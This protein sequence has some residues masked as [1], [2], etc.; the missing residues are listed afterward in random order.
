MS[1]SLKIRK[2]PP[3]PLN[4]QINEGPSWPPAAF[5]LP[6]AESIADHLLRTFEIPQKSTPRPMRNTPMPIGPVQK[7]ANPISIFYL[8]FLNDLL[9]TDMLTLRHKPPGRHLPN[10]RF[11]GF[12]LGFEMQLAVIFEMTASL[13]A[14][15]YK[16][17]P[18]TQSFV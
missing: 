18:C 12:I 5:L 15:F 4:N 8:L 2:I 16:S 1:S 14:N 10:G 7:S 13:P 9:D 11:R 3:R 6:A 17:Y